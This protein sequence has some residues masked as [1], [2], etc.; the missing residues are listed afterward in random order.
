MSAPAPATDRVT[1]F[2]LPAVFKK[3]NDALSSKYSSKKY[4]VELAKEQTDPKQPVYLQFISSTEKERRIGVTHLA[5]LEGKDWDKQPFEKIA[6][7]LDEVVK[8]IVAR[9]DLFLMAKKNSRYTIADNGT[10]YDFN[11]L[12]APN[13][14]GMG[15]FFIIDGAKRHVVKWDKEPLLLRQLISESIITLRRLEEGREGLRRGTIEFYDPI[16]LRIGK[17]MFVLANEQ[18][19][20]IDGEIIRA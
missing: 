14:D 5:K 1:L 16:D 17:G 8:A 19:E 4:N 2:D 9:V 12:G 6:R 13:K 11:G 18:G 20:I 10:I 15:G 3:A 7:R